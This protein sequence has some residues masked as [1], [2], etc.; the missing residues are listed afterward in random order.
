MVYMCYIQLLNETIHVES[1]LIIKIYKLSFFVIFTPNKS[2]YSCNFI[3]FF[4]ITY[5][6]TAEFYHK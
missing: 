6:F 1:F 5:D 2:S 3:P 4:Q